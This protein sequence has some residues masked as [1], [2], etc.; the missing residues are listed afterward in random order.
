MSLLRPP[1]L[2]VGDTIGVCTP[3]YP[4]HTRLRAKYLHGVEVLRRMGFVVVEGSLTARATDQGHRAGSA[5]ERAEELNALFA[6]ASV[7]C[8]ICTI[9][10]N[11]SASIA[12]FLDYALIRSNPKVFCGYS[13]VTSLHLA[14]MR[15]AGL[16]T[17][18]G[19]A[20]MPSFGEWPDVLPETRDSF[21]DAVCRHTAGPRELRAP[22]RW[23]NHFRDAAGDAWRSE[24][25][26]WQDNPGW[27]SLA[28][29]VAEGPALICNLNTL[30]ANAGTVLMPDLAGTVLFIEDMASSASLGERSFRQLAAMPGFAHLRGLVWGKVES[31]THEPGAP[32]LESLLLEAVGDALGG[33]PRFPIVGGFDC[34]HTV[35]MLTL[36]QGTPVR[37]D[38]SG[39][40]AR[41]HVLAP[42]V[43]PRS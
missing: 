14:L 20:V 16:S 15:H 22:Q 38:A 35:P 7:R 29:G 11:V 39:P 40:W 37:V 27:Q 41:V 2:R 8:I 23:S 21:L 6:D 33:S 42:M 5:R 18:Y 36:A 4:A 24:P 30:R 17:F 26:I 10:G 12:P 3:S 1:A 31:L 32:S 28:P 43:T 34:C 25:R 19:P 13:D 9:G